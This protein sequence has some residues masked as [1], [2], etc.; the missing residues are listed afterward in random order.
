MR[1]LALFGVLSM[2]V[3]MPAHSGT[4]RP[5]GDAG[6]ATANVAPADEYRWMEDPKRAADMTAWVRKASDASVDM[7]GRLPARAAFAAELEAITRAGV[8]YSDLRSAGG[9]LFYRRLDP[10]ARTAKLVVREAGG[11]R[12]I[13]DPEQGTSDVRSISNYSVSPDGSTLA[14]HVASGGGEVGH[15]LFLDAATGAQKGAPLGPIWGE[16]EVAWLTD[17]MVA[18]TRLPEQQPGIDI[19][20]NNRIAVTA[21]GAAEPG[22]FV[23]GP[24]VAGPVF[25]E[26]EFP[27]LSSSPLSGWVIGYGKNARADSRV[28]LARS[29]D[30]ASGRARWIEVAGY[31][32]RILAAAVQG[33]TLFLLTTAGD[34]NGTVLRHR[35][36]DAGLSDAVPIRVDGTL[37]LVQLATTRDGL[38]VVGHREGAARL[39]FVPHGADEAEAVELPMEGSIFGLRADL[40]GSSV[41]FGLTGWFTA[42]RFHRARG[43]RVE[44]LG[45]ESDTW[46][47]AAAFKAVREE[48]VS[49]DGTR[50]PMVILM[51]T[52]ATPG[53][54]APTI[55]E[56]Y[57]S[58]GALSLGPHYDPYDMAW[59]A[60]GGVLALC[61]TRGGGERG[62]AWHEAGRSANKPRAHEDFIGCAEHLVNRGYATPAQLIAK[63]TSAG[64]LLATPAALKRPEL[65]T[66]VIPRVAVLNP[67][68]LAEAENGA[69]QFPELGDPRTKE[70][71][72]ALVAQDSYL[73][74]AGAADAPDMLVTLGLN[75]RRVTPWMP[76]KFAARAQD[77]FGDRRR[78][79]IRAEVEGGHGMGSARDRLIA[80]Y[81]D[82]Y[83][84]AW[85]EATEH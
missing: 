24:G 65:F 46:P 84:F 11:E 25:D 3:V 68:R 32:D 27:I 81:A 74:L 2:A 80:E 57:G 79:L 78:I 8:R 42:S 13:L 66:A 36:T 37:S 33:D 52:T 72:A 23:L 39:L 5:G 67:T 15:A 26:A 10:T 71:F 62:R 21:A 64:G 59:L 73:M 58:Y 1:T 38:Y 31:D 47:G 77:R 35:I 17:A 69:N 48:A 16:D 40:E 9:R 60:R 76:A 41:T 53:R 45:I 75:D 85:S 30:L 19:M 50:V 18:Y 22:R 14:V 34:T 7:L 83:A 54:P 63:G 12:I 43:G 56:G 20:K 55:L 6:Q 82:T 70:G 4:P 44:P 51:G 49:A 61:G 29:E 28:L